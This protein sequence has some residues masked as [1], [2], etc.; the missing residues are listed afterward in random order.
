[1]AADTEEMRSRWEKWGPYV[2]DRSWGT[3]RE[4]DGRGKETWQAFPYEM[5]PY[6]CYR[7][8]ED[9]VAGLCDR[10]QVLVL[11]HAFWNR[12]DPLLKERLYGL[13]PQQGNHGE[14]V[15]ELYYYLDAT[16]TFSYLRFLYKFPL[17][18][19]PYDR[20]KEENT[21]RTLQDREFE[22]VDTGIFAENRY[23]DVVIEYAKVSPDDIVVH[24]TF[25]NRSGHL[26]EFDYLAQL[27]F[28]NTWSP[29]GVTAPAL[30]HLASEGS[31]GISIVCDDRGIPLI[32]KL[33]M[34][35]RLGRRYFY[36]EGGGIPL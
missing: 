25:H 30:M 26:A 9:G 1:M 5:A 35:Y 28:R 13:T 31:E 20:L 23:I 7:W 8:G 21:H 29:R 10:Y 6:R 14:D 16:P 19:F 2:A 17:S 4:D 27:F 34:E 18:P 15:K 24:L 12:K 32:D 11:N 3:V 22:L 33:T 36:A